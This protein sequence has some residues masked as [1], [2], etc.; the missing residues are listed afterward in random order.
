MQR[1][2]SV[3]DLFLEIAAV[4]S[5]SG[6]ERAVADHVAAYADELGLLAEEDDSASATGGSMGNLLIRIPA[7]NGSSG[8]P[9]L[10][11]AHLDTVP[12]H[13]AMKPAVERGIV[14]NA[15]GETILG[16]DDKAAVAVLLEAARRI[17]EDGVAH[18]GIELLFTPMEEMACKGAKE[19]DPGWL[20]ARSGFVYDDARPVG[21]MVLAAPYG[22][23]LDAV[24]RGRSAHAGMEPEAGRSAIHAAAEGIA[25]VRQGRIDKETTLNFGL[26]HG[27]TA[28][29]VV[30]DACSVTVDLRS[31]SEC[32]VHQLVKDVS[33]SL[34]AAAREA[35]CDVAFV[36]DEKYR[37]YRFTDSDPI[38]QLASKGLVAAGLRPF[39]A[40]GGGGSDANVLNE[41]GISCINLAN[42]MSAIH[43]KHEQIAVADL[44]AMVDV[45]L[46]LVDAARRRPG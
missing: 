9:L 39:G 22:Y 2:P 20:Q 4:P 24:F 19:L 43:T 8:L 33:A 15:S 12:V 10:F 25:R 41:Y 35:G 28:P 36:V 5:P 17:L 30:A 21:G 37:G 18:P 44:N 38:V 11:C 16:A 27:G 7:T 46:A 40:A 31:R 6:Q 29:N 42:G 23:R 14:R 34:G 32:K 1:L 26:I 13:G 45:T 3:L